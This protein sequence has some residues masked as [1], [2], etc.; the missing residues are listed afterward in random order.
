MSKIMTTSIQR[1]YDTKLKA[2][3][4]AKDAQVLADAKAH[5]QGLVDGMTEGAVAENSAAIETLGQTVSGLKTNLE[6]ADEDLGKRIDEVEGDVGNLEGLNTTAKGDLVNAI[7]EVRAAVTAGGTAAAI[8]IDTTTTTTGA[9]KSYTIK[10]GQNTIGTIDIPKDMVV[11]S[12]EVV[13]N[14][15]GQA[16]GTYIK[17]VLANVTEP[18]FINV[19]TLIDIYRA[20]ASATQVQVAID[21]STREISATIVAGS[22]GTTELAD[23]AVTTAKIAEGNVTLAKL[24]TGVQ[25][26]LGK[27]DTAV[28]KVEVGATNGT[29]KVDGKEVAVAGL[30]SAAFAES[31]AFDAAGAADAVQDKLDEEVE[32]AKKAEAQALTDAKSYVNGIIGDANSGVTKEIADVKGRMDAEE[33]KSTNFESRIAAEEAK[34]VNFESRIATLEGVEYA[35]E[36]D[37]DTM[38]A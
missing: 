8:T 5:A 2:W 32:R 31:S 34:S 30:K 17:L 6:K 13:T 3:V 21:S 4:V 28:Q 26:S 25:T 35:T 1:Y 11:Q 16:A 20:K 9:L 18:L 24:S 27:A 37:I 38:F 22:I 12:G 14:P 23:G 19:G 33:A 10:Q 15:S 36:A 29:I 7:N